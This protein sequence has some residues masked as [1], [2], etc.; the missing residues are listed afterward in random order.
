MY[1]INVYEFP[2]AIEFLQGIIIRL[3]PFKSILLFPGTTK[4]IQCL[5]TCLN[6][7]GVAKFP[8]AIKI[9]KALKI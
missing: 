9:I 8:G 4:L 1:I 6:C 2:Y 5:I 3:K 7:M